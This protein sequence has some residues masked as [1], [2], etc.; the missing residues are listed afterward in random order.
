L[1]DLKTGV[2]EVV[3]KAEEKPPLFDRQYGFG[4]VAINLNYLDDEMK[5]SL[6]PTDTRR[7]QD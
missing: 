6:P 5:K 1:K 7:R 3:F 4:Y 2:D